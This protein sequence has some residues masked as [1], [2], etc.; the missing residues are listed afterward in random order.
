MLPSHLE[1]RVKIAKNDMICEGKS[2]TL[3]MNAYEILMSPLQIPFV[4]DICLLE[5]Y[6]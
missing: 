1:I 3:S 4:I 6:L 2:K 5:S